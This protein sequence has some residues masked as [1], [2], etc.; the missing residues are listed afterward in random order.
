MNTNNGPEVLLKQIWVEID[1]K[2]EEIVEGKVIDLGDMEEKIQTLCRVLGSLPATEAQPFTNDLKQIMTTL[3]RWSSLLEAR[4]K[5]ILQG[6]K[7]LN[8]Q[9]RA[10]TAYINRLHSTLGPSDSQ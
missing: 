4:K 8:T 3:A 5:D 1:K 6:V 10:Q 7:Q 9:A 2:E